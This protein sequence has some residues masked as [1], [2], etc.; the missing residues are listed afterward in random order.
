MQVH[1][2]GLAWEPVI[3]HHFAADE[4]FK[5]E[6]GEHVEP[7]AEARDVHHGVVGGEVVK[8]VAFGLGAEGEEAG[9]GH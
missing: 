4:G 2:E 3:E 7:E 5:W 9:E 6:R 8:D 1:V